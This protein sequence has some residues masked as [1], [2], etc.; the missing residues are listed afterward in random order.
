MRVLVDTNVLLRA[1]QRQHPACRIAI[2][3]LKTL[4]QQSD[5]LCVSPQ[6]VAEFWNVCTRPTDVNGMGLSIDATDRYVK[7]LERIFTV[8]PD[9]LE[10]FHQ[11]RTLL[12][13]HQVIGTK[14]HDAHLIAVMMAH[15]IRQILTFNV[16]D[17]TRF[18]VEATH[19]T[20]LLT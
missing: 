14:V 12:V 3:A 17:F 5:I 10:T 1:V 7:R 20:A 4:R 15:G 13:Q 9:S 19:P 11:W 18:P 16:A 8:V 2:N 6:N